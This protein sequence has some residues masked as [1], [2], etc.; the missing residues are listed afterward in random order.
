MHNVTNDIESWS[1]I[2]L[3]S[4]VTL[5]LPLLAFIFMAVIK[6]SAEKLSA[7][8][9]TAIMFIA[10]A[11]AVYI[12]FQVWPNES[13]AGTLNWIS[14]SNG[15]VVNVG[16]LINF[17]AAAMLIVVLSISSL[18]HLYS[19]KYM[20]DDEGFKR[21]FAFLAFFTFSMIGIVIAD[22]LLAIFVFWELVGLSSY[23][24][25]G[26]W[27]K[28]ESA[29]FAASKAFIV[30]RVG[31]VGFVLGIAILWTHFQTLDL[32]ALSMAMSES[33]IKEGVWEF[34]G[35]SID[36]SW[37]TVAGICLFLGA[38]GKSAQFPL[39]I[40]LPDAM[41]GPT[42]ISALI[43]AATMV[44]AGVYLMIRVF[45]LLNIDALTVIATIGAITAFM[46]AIA[47]LTQ[48]DI[49][50]VLAYSTISQLGYMLMGIGV[51]AYGA[52]FFHLFTHAFFKACLFL[53]AGS[54][55]YALHEYSA[56]SKN[57]FDTQDMRNMGGLR[58][59]LPV[60]FTA[61][62]IASLALIGIP[63]FSGFLSKDALLSGAYAWASLMGGEGFSL[64]Y[65]I[66]DLGF[67]TVVL[68]AVYMCRQILL[69]F[70][71]EFRLKGTTDVA[72]IESPLLLR[73]TLVILAM[74][75]LGL[76]WSFNPFDFNTSW[77]LS[78]V[79]VPEI[80][81]PDFDQFWQLSLVEISSKNH[82]LISTASILLVAVGLAIGYYIYRPQGR[83][84]LNY[85][86]R[87]M[88]KHFMQKI[89]YYN[90][91]LDPFYFYAVHRPVLW[92]SRGCRWV[93]RRLIDRGI[94]LFGIFNVIFAHGIAWLDRYVVDG[95]VNLA[96]FVAGRFGNL[97]RSIQGGK[98]QNYLVLAILGLILIIYWSI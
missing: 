88:A 37:L 14:F 53:S 86:T 78:A 83:Y 63:F 41:E 76:V 33:I 95:M 1:I 89:S 7:A 18:V 72:V 27:Y 44:A 8:I 13:F 12:C 57:K 82:L 22:N 43:H 16:V 40:W 6:K 65:L 47:A 52:A 60:T 70:F 59:Y 74:L 36:A 46:G 4:V 94:N 24:L 11:L 30:N 98:V 25:I 26:H 51:G 17:E 58:K 50:K 49:K 66:P 79:Q 31:D 80:V 20:Q 45:T 15:S 68:T 38:V 90:W 85:A 29:S 48:H 19:L 67:I 21:Y 35:Q 10:T 23:L 81:T 32:T 71:G 75:S 2:A 77:F 87:P 9:S 56:K 3:L 91:Y 34:G 55:I 28:K 62:L 69:V 42:P 64:Y 93:D 5:L 73:I 97:T 84:V 39:Q 61:Y 92:L 96:V 54:V